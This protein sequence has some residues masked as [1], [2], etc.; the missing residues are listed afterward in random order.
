MYSTEHGACSHNSCLLQLQLSLG[1]RITHM[2][3][4]FMKAL[5]RAGR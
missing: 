4:V 3:K 2:H 5:N 1:Q